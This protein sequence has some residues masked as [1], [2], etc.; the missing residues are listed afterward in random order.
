MGHNSAPYL[1]HVT[2]ALKLAFADREAYLGDPRFVK[3]IPIRGMLAKEYAAR[4]RGL[5]RRDRAMAGPALPTIRATT[6]LSRRA[7]ATA[8]ARIP[9]SPAARLIRT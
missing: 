5:I 8:P 7:T 9:C 3:D 4:R 2:E 6:L 1:H